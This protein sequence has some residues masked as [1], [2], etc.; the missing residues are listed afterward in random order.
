M[1]DG[2]YFIAKILITFANL[3]KQGKDLTDLIA[4][5][6]SPLEEAD[7]RLNFTCEN[8]RELADKIMPRLNGLAERLLRLSEDNYE[9]VR[10]YVSHADGYFIVRT[11]V[12]DPVLPIYIESDKVGGA[13][14]IARFLYSFFNGF[15]GI[16]CAPLA[17]FIG[18]DEIAENVEGDDVAP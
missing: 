3:K 8:W 15:T 4:D 17:E 12:H 18:E 6:S 7:I 11:S 5:L 9:G 13:R 14:S 10:A 2:A 16:D 1:D